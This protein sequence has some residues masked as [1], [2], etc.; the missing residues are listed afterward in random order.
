M[1]RPPFEER[2]KLVM[3]CSISPA[4]RTLI[5][6]TSTPSDRAHLPPAVLDID[7]II[8]GRPVDLAVIADAVVNLLLVRF[9]PSPFGPQFLLKGLTECNIT[10]D[11][12]GRDLAVL[13]ER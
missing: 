2:T 3:L 8:A 6:L 1:I 10:V 5:G 9:L 12:V 7:R 4:S 11:H 13:K